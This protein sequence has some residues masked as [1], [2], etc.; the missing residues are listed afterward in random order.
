MRRP[1]SDKKLAVVFKQIDQDGSGE[2]EFEEFL[3]WWR[4]EGDGA[5]PPSADEVDQRGEEAYAEVCHYMTQPLVELYGGCMV[6][7]K[8]S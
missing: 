1:I 6:V 5:P 4:E 3:E 2:L 7:L 8:V